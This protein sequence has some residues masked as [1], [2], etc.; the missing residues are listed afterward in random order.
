MY[1]N[2]YNQWFLFKI[3]RDRDYSYPD[4]NERGR[5]SSMNSLNFSDNLDIFKSMDK[6]YLFSVF[7]RTKYSY[8]MLWTLFHKTWHNL[9]RK[10]CRCQH[11]QHMN[12][13]TV[14]WSVFTFNHKPLDFYRQGLNIYL[15]IYLEAYWLKSRGV[16]FSTCIYR[17]LISLYL[18]QQQILI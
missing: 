16:W 5:R 1:L 14:C 2:G 17:Y 4:E 3:V 10:R 18:K 9:T 6:I 13:N 8:L 15:V 7:Q 11:G 12:Q